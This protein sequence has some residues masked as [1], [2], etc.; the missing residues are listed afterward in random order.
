MKKYLAF[1]KRNLKI[2][3][4]VKILNL[5]IFLKKYGDSKKII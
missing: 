3:Q 1:G 5:L 4:K 2:S